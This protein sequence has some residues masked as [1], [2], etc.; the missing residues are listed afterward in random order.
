MQV[1]KATPG[2]RKLFA[3]QDTVF[4]IGTVQIMKCRNKIKPK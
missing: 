2:I 4:T 1:S 3:S